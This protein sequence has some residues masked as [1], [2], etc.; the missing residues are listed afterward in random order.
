MREQEYILVSSLAYA[1]G[2]LV[3]RLIQRFI[4]SFTLLSCCQQPDSE[5]RT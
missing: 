5:F 3:R 1:A 2:F 4:Y